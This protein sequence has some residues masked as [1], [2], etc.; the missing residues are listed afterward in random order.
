MSLTRRIAS[1][2]WSH[3]RTVPGYPATEVKRS[4]LSPTQML[5]P[6]EMSTHQPSWT[7][8]WPSRTSES[9][10]DSARSTRK[11]ETGRMYIK[12]C[13]MWM[14]AYPMT[15]YS[16]WSNLSPWWTLSSVRTCRP[17]L[18][19]TSFALTKSAL[20]RYRACLMSLVWVTEPDACKEMSR[21]S[22]LSAFMWWP[23]ELTSSTALGR[24]LLTSLRWLISLMR[25]Y[26]VW[27]KVSW[28]NL[29][30]PLLRQSQA[31]VVLLAKILA[32]VSLTLE[33]MTNQ[34]LRRRVKSW[35]RS[36][37]NSSWWSQACSE[38]TSSSTTRLSSMTRTTWSTLLKSLLR[39]K[40][41]S[42]CTKSRFEV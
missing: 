41:Y 1:M 9:I 22:T 39:S 12:S 28:A 2:W 5:L 6:R 37:P 19:H 7:P 20:Q 32:A 27:S 18:S 38:I 3:R 10:L 42:V 17:W 30:S 15:R 29:L 40:A 34:S 4:P 36:F 33:K 31:A 21:R 35:R 8:S 24:S 23:V 26:L 13:K 11:S 14:L 16:T 25:C